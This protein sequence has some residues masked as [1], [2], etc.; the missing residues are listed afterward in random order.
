MLR[1]AICDDETTLVNEIYKI[2]LHEISKFT[3]E[4]EI[5]CFTNGNNL[6]EQHQEN[7][8][9]I[10]FL[11]IDMPKISG[12]EIAKKLRENFSKAY[13][14]FITSHEELVY[15]SMDFQPFH[16][17]R[18]HCNTPLEES[19]SSV[20]KKLINLLKQNY[21]VSLE[22]EEVGTVAV[23]LRDVIMLASNGH[24]VTFT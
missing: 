3:T 19:I 18:K 22:D 16:F 21:T 12:F 9:E 2:V 20:I 14:I 1:I 5:K 11:D 6:L 23:M 15:E 17:L 8:F 10:V 13:I 24:Y 7:P 4:V